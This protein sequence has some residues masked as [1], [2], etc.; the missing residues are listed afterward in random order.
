MSEQKADLINSLTNSLYLE[1]DFHK[2]S[3]V[4]A[5]D[6]A[7]DELRQVVRGIFTGRRCIVVGSAPAFVPP[8]RQKEDLIL[9]VNGSAFQLAKLGVEISDVSLVNGAVFSSAFENS[10][11][12][13]FSEVS[14]ATISVLKNGRARHC[15]VGT[16]SFSLH[17]SLKRLADINYCSDHFYEMSGLHRISLV[18]EACGAELGFGGLEEKASTGVVAI[19]LAL[20]GGAS[21]V[22]FAGFSLV[23]GHCYV[24]SETRRWHTIGD[25]EF[26]RL[27][28]QNKL[29][30]S[31]TDKALAEQFGIPEC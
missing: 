13:E 20:W 23:G 16:N 12:N 11:V 26:F 4:R 2:I 9:T 7:Y 29:P 3:A 18:G 15:F 17:D 10:G 27:C 28:G 30:V 21:E 22:A 31:T 25:R 6:R 19:C 24:P 1:R 8:H 5:S 14:R